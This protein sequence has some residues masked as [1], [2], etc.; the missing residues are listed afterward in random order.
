MSKELPFVIVSGHIFKFDQQ[1]V[2]P[3]VKIPEQ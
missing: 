1:W 2:D 3:L